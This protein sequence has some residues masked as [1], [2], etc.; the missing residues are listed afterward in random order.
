MLFRNLFKNH[1]YLNEIEDIEH[2][3]KSE[4]SGD[5]T[6]ITIY[7]AIGSYWFMDS[8]SASDIKNVLKD[9]ESKEIVIHLNSGGGDAFDG[10]AIYNQLKNHDAKIIVHIDGFA[11]SAASIIAMAADEL[12]MHTGTMMMIHEASTVAWGTKKEVRSAL[13]ALEGLDK[14]LV[15]IYMTR[16][17]GERSEMETFIENETWFTVDEAVAVG[18][19]D[20][21]AD[22]DEDRA[23]PEAFKNSVLARFQKQPVA[24]TNKNV[25]ERFKRPI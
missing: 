16:F 25:L 15:D 13:N 19:A 9:N 3:F 11:A 6:E 4:T 22:P 1:Q 21:A 17:K 7:G 20:K 8:T 14:S 23:E 10:I 12:I 24:S 5:K 18:L 2:E